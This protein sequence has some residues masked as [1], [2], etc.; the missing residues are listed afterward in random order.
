MIIP[1]KTQPPE[2]QNPQKIEANFYPGDIKLR[3]KQKPQ[4]INFTDTKT[5]SIFTLKAAPVSTPN[6]RITDQKTAVET[7]YILSR[8]KAHEQSPQPAASTHPNRRK[9]PE[10]SHQNLRQNQS[11]RTIP[12]HAL[13][14]INPAAETHQKHRKI[15]R[16][17][18]E[19]PNGKLPT[20]RRPEA[21]GG[22]KHRA[23]AAAIGDGVRVENS[24]R[25]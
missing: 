24:R 11:P 17:C 19:N 10:I 15:P 13:R 22:L 5:R 6:N 23:G 18:P 9:I 12:P 14:N 1:T 4:K 16:N 7:C 2:C 8:S 3:L 21:L 20:L 25:G